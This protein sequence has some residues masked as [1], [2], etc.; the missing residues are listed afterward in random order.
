METSTTHTKSENP[1]LKRIIALDF[2]RGCAMIGVIGFHL[3]NVTYDYGAR[4]AL[5]L[6]DIPIAYFILVAILGF[7]GSL[8][9]AFILT[10]AI[11]NTISMDKKWHKLLAQDNS[12]EG[13]KRAFTKILKMQIS[14][15]LFLIIADF[16][17]EGLINGAFMSVLIGS[18]EEIGDDILSDLYH[19][20]ILAIIGV[21]VILT[22]IVYLWCQYKQ[23][24]KKALSITLAVVGAI[25][26]LGTPLVILGFDALPGLV[27]SP[28]DT[29]ADRTLGMNILYFFLS[30]LVNGWYPWFP[31]ASLFFLGS[32]IAVNFTPTKKFF[33]Q[34]TLASI[35]YLVLGL[36]WNFLFFPEDRYVND[37]L[38]PTAGSIFLLVIL[39]YFIDIRGKGTNFAKNKVVVFI[40]RFGNLSLTIWA[41]QWLMVPYL[42]VV[43]RIVDGSSIA[44]MDSRFYLEGLTGN[45]TWA[46]FFG[47]LP[48]WGL[49]LWGWE[50]IN[51]KGSL[52]W[53]FVSIVVKKKSGELGSA[54]ADLRGTIHNIESIIPAEE[55]QRWYKPWELVLIFG[56]LLVLIVASLALLL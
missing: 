34:L 25:F 14:R 16:I 43:Q 8:F 32:I 39:I 54:K 7:A 15:G 9:P 28:N 3:M 6:E 21:G 55:G 12:E 31:N 23:V 24:S 4:L 26:I 30:P 40:R 18:T 10:S 13:R 1:P 45:Q 5:P 38:V 33:Q 49:L 52:E 56:Y 35:G 11:G 44:F 48:L 53:L 47:M 42:Q 22:A 19:Y 37:S 41:I 29:L 2:L 20:Q 36:L 51:Y 27:G 17:I 50:Q 46:L